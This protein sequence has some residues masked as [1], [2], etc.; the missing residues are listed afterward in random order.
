MEILV[1]SVIQYV[2][3]N[4][5]R[6]FKQLG[7]RLLS[8]ENH[9]GSRRWSLSGSFPHR[10]RGERAACRTGQA[11]RR[12]LFRR[13]HSS[14]SGC[15]HRREIPPFWACEMAK[16]DATSEARDSKNRPAADTES[17]DEEVFH[18]ARFPP[19]EEAVRSIT[20]S[21]QSSDSC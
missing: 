7:R 12:Q 5:K 6:R 11:G 9:L 20:G 21:P 15:S 14:S 19:E 8:V 18:D 1:I 17:E 10:R 4:V 3:E 2:L 13:P 16:R